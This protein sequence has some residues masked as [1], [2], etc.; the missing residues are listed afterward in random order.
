MFAYSEKGT[1]F[2]NSEDY[3]P[4][5]TESLIIEFSPDQ[6][7]FNLKDQELK[8]LNCKYVW[9]VISKI[10]KRE[11]RNIEKGT[12]SGQKISDDTWEIEIDIDT[13][14]KFGGQMDGQSSR[15]IKLKEKIKTVPNIG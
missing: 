1:T 2:L 4:V 7:D 6:T 11:V 13:Q 3:D 14:F 12:I 15:K 5:F 8:N 10:P 9:T